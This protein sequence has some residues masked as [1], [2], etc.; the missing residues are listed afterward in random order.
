[1]N[2]PIQAR[3]RTAIPVLTAVDVATATSFWVDTLGFS[4]GL[5]D[6]QF[7]IVRRDDIELFLT[8]VETQLIPD[9]TQAWIRV[10][11]LESLHQEWAGKVPAHFRETSGAAMTPIQ[12]QPWGRE[13]ALRDPAGNCVHFSEIPAPT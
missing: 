13:F 7:A 4:G 10:S 2:Q 6:P 3:L 5:V 1:M 11:D 9:N 8:T 12:S